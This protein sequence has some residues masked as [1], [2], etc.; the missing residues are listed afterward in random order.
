MVLAPSAIEVLC[1]GL[2]AKWSPNSLQEY[3]SQA[4][5]EDPFS[6]PSTA[7]PPPPP[8]LPPPP[9]PPPPHPLFHHH[10]PPTQSNPHWQCAAPHLSSLLLLFI[11]LS[12]PRTYRPSGFSL[13]TPAHM[14]AFTFG[15]FV[16]T[17]LH[18][19]PSVPFSSP[20]LATWRCCMCNEGR[21]TCAHIQ[22]KTDPGPIFG[23][24]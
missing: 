19:F 16:C 23:A 15:Y 5:R 20:L 4:L 6:T 2:H 7:H 17:L 9:P 21:F 13:C 14:Q 12:R 11:S 3:L 24:L 10:H 1:V 18:F 22:I 8:L